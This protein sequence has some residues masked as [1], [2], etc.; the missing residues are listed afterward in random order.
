MPLLASMYEKYKAQ[1]LQVLGINV[2]KEDA[3]VA[4]WLGAHPMPFTLVR[5]PNGVMMATFPNRGLPTTLWV[6]KDGTIRLRTTGIPPG[7]DRRIEELV[8]ELLSL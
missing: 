5:D 1:G 4:T 6:R 2:D 7:G 3:K 8:T